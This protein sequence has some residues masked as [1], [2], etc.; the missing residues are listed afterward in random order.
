[1]NPKFEKKKETTTSSLVMYADYGSIS[2]YTDTMDSL[3]SDL[4]DADRDK[5]EDVT[6]FR[7]F[8]AAE[9]AARSGSVGFHSGKNGPPGEGMQR[10]AVHTY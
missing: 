8:G 5:R 4:R 2:S 7:R 1:M 10:R 3:F 6:R 9:A